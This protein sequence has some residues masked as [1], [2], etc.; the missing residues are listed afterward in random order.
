MLQFEN[1]RLLTS[2]LTKLKINMQADDGYTGLTLEEL[3]K[4]PSEPII[5]EPAVVHFKSVPH[6]PLRKTSGFTSAL[7]NPIQS[8]SIKKISAD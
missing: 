4:L 8:V 2:V 6:L 1:L 5:Q 7:L 3:L